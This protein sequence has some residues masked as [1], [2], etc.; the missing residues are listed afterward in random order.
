MEAL[1]ALELKMVLKVI[2]LIHAPVRTGKCLKSWKISRL[3]Q[4]LALFVHQFRTA[5]T[6]AKR[7]EVC[8]TIAQNA[9]R[10]AVSLVV[11]Q[12]NTTISIDLGADA[13]LLG[14]SSEFALVLIWGEGGQFACA[15]NSGVCVSIGLAGVGVSFGVST[16]PESFGG[17]DNVGNSWKEPE[18]CL[19][20]GYSVFVGV[21]ATLSINPAILTVSLAIQ[22]IRTHCSPH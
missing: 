5:A 9:A 22:L 6:S 15:E 17:W 8:Q 10:K 18:I 7:E 2:L 4:T 19:S 13:A 20:V 12:L 3:K 14:I 11:K 21:A 16:S 1:R